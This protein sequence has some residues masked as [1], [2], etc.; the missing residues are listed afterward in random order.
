MGNQYATT[1]LNK[2]DVYIVMIALG[3]GAS[4]IYQTNY[5]LIATAFT[6]INAAMMRGC[7]PTILRKWSEGKKDEV[8]TL[9]NT[10][11]RL[12]LIHISEPTRH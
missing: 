8:Q 11:V 3:A 4:G 9:L 1:I 12:S 7:Y 10:A 2:S 6:L 5:S